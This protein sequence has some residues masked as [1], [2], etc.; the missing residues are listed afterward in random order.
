MDS[1]FLKIISNSED[2]NYLTD[3]SAFNDLIK[4]SEEWLIDQ[5]LNY[6]K[7]HG[8]SKYTSTEKE[9]WRLSISGMSDALIKAIKIDMCDLELSPDDDY[10]NDPVSVFG[11]LEAKRHREH[12]IDL[13]KFLGLMKYYRQSYLDLVQRSGFKPGYIKVCSLI[14][15]R[16]FDRFEIGLCVEWNAL[17]ENKKIKELKSKNR[18]I[19]NEKNKYLTIF[20]TNQYPMMLLDRKNRIENVNHAWSELFLG[21]VVPGSLYYDRYWTDNQ[22]YWFAD[23]LVSLMDNEKTEYIFEKEIETKKGPR[24]FQVKIKKMLNINNKYRGMVIILNDI[25]D[26]KKAEMERL[27]KEKL[28]GVLELAGAVCHEL[29]QPLQVVMGESQLMEMDI[30]KNSP[31]YKRILAIMNQVERVNIITKKL[32]SITKYETKEYLNSKIIDI[33]KASNEV[34]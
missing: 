7:S 1:L 29:N 8:Y 33:D 24:Y 34:L 10:S 16:F 27:K 18:R 3:M 13:S 21:S 20:E 23:E 4:K 11:I 15:E 31:F 28:Q 25:T 22:A 17:I 9:P 12:G 26:L 2:I 19:T 14:I 5:I 6:S 30:K 32:M